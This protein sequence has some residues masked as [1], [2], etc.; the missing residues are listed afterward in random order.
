M[1]NNM[2]IQKFIPS[3]LRPKS[4]SIR[5]RLMLYL[6]LMILLGFSLVLLMLI[7]TGYIFNSDKYLIKSMEMQQNRSAADLTLR[8]DSIAA[9][10]IGLSEMLG[11]EMQKKLRESDIKAESL[12]DNHGM[13]M[14]IQEA[15][16]PYLNTTLRIAKCTGAFALINATTNTALGENSKS[17][18]YLRFS[19]ISVSEPA[20]P[21]INYF[22]GIPEIAR[23]NHIEMHNR[24]ELEF[25]SSFPYFDEFMNNP[26][27]RISESFR[28]SKSIQL[29]NTWEEAM[30][31]VLP[32]SDCNS[33]I[34]GVCGLEFSSLYFKLH[35]PAVKTEFGSM[36]TVLAPMRGN[37]LYLGEGLVGG[38]DGIYFDR[39]ETLDITY[40]KRL[41]VY[42]AGSA[43]YVGIQKLL[44]ISSD[45]QWFLCTLI[46][47][48]SHRQFLIEEK[49]RWGIFIL[50][51]TAIMLIISLIISRNF[52]S[53]IT[54]ALDSIANTKDMEASSSG[55][56]ELDKLMHF[57]NERSDKEGTLHSACSPLNTRL[58]NKF[59]KNFKTLNSQEQSI[60]YYYLEGYD[61]EK[62]SSL[63]YISPDT[64]E[65]YNQTIYQKL[66][67]SSMDELLLYIDLIK[68]SD[69]VKDLYGY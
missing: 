44:P 25:A 33:E 64:I 59:L 18:M 39:R 13:L 30:L 47:S 4:I 3:S 28:W 45:E 63:S 24:W 22:R 23:N 31:L 61:V 43:S 38:I 37:K 46:S 12:N 20:N 66:E 49:I 11:T 29:T 57:L 5:H 27:R 60:F 34:Y 67:I 14:K 62:L 51:F 52:A 15:F 9:Q 1:Q 7:T 50:V 53:P 42:K 6:I 36:I 65:K 69:R 8:M 54:E 40:G 41:N 17:G 56:S 58:C 19:N 32:F 10:G 2:K 48:E 55:I 16:Y 26:P 35:Y 21:Q 68:R